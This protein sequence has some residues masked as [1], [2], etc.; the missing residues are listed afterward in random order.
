MIKKCYIIKKRF[1]KNFE[2]IL[3]SIWVD[4]KSIVK[5]AQKTE[6][7]EINKPIQKNVCI[8]F[9]TNIENEIFFGH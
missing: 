8:N 7:T 9:E 2:K 3:K 1:W 5:A 4:L 6:S